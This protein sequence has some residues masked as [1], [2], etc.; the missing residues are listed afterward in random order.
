[1][2]I[3]IFTI[4]LVIIILQDA[5]L[6]VELNFSNIIKKYLNY[7]KLVNIVIKSNLVGESQ[8]LSIQHLSNLSL[9]LV[10]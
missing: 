7:K 8:N 4:N 3:N 9:K 6:C 10:V 2:T 1:M 5:K